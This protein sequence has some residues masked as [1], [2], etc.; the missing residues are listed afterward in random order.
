MDTERY[1][2]T[3]WIQGK[4][5]LRERREREEIA[6]RRRTQRQEKRGER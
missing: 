2:M 6:K 5:R 1:A 4:R 3:I